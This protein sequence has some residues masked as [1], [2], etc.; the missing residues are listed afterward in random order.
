MK[1]KKLQSITLVEYEIIESDGEFVGK[2]I[3]SEKHP[4]YFT[5][6]S[7]MIGRDYGILEKGLEDELLS[8]L[9]SLGTDT[10]KSA[11]AG[12][13]VDVSDVMFDA[14][15]PSMDR[16]K[17]IIWL[18]YVGAKTSGEYLDRDEFKELF[19]PDYQECMTTYVGVLTS[20]FSDQP[21]KFSDGLKKSTSKKKT[22]KQ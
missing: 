10:A 14:G 16:M 4:L 19:N 18:A 13:E 15:L 2:E 17:D 1:L 8:L 7:L 20:N 22:V 3:S 9:V 12:K 21:N 6:R 5:N 11:M